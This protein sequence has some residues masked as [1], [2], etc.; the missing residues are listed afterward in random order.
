MFI[1]VRAMAAF[2]LA[3]AMCGCN[4]APVGPQQQPQAPEQGGYGP[5]PSGPQQT[6]NAPMPNSPTPNAPM[7]GGGEGVVSGGGGD[8]PA[9]F[10]QLVV[11]YLDGYVNQM[12]PGWL[13]V[14][15]VPDTITGLQLNGEHRWQL[16]LRAG[17]SYAFV[18]A[19]DN[20]CSNIDFVLEDGGGRQVDT[21][22]LDDD[23]PLVEVT[24]PA[25]GVYTLRIQLRTCT[26]APCYVAARLVARP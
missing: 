4:Q 25:D 24:P 16:R 11:G 8:A 9:Q 14:D 12:T 7:T 13:R 3:A 20:E 22:V 6:P 19:C 23:Y 1:K 17:R 5:M 2:V 21:D 10:Q 26:I 15:G 18:G